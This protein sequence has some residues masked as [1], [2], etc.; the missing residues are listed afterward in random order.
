MNSQGIYKCIAQNFSILTESERIS[1]VGGIHQQNLTN[2]D[3]EI[4]IIEDQMCVFL[5]QNI[6]QHFPKI[7]HLDVRNTGLE[8][9]TSSQM[10]M[11]PKLKHLYIRNNPIEVLP[12]NVF[13]FNPLLEFINLNDNK[14]KTIGENIFQSLS[15]LI[16]LS[17]ERN[18]CIDNFALQEEPLKEL[19]D[20]VARKC[21]PK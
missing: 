18:V 1:N 4:F 16:S 13:Q 20:E 9:I 3:V 17:I 7:Y 6:D 8:A 19:I 21:S 5:P 15:K 14:L 10:K 12:A 2:Q 11:F